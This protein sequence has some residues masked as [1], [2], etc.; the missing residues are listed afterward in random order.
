MI[1]IFKH[2]FTLP[3]MLVAALVADL[4]AAIAGAMVEFTIYIDALPDRPAGL[5]HIMLTVAAALCVNAML[6]F[7]LPAH[8]RDARLLARRAAFSAL[9]SA[10]LMS[11]LLWTLAEGARQGHVLASPALALLAATYVFRRGA[12]SGAP[13]S[14]ACRRILVFGTGAAALS[15]RQPEDAAGSSVEVLGYYPAA[16]SEVPAVPPERILPTAGRTLTQTALE[17]RVDEIVV[18]LNDRRGGALP[19]P[20]LLQCRVLGIRVHDLSTHFERSRGQIR[21]ESLRSGWLVF[22][23]GFEQGLLRRF[24]K[25]VFDIV[26]AGGMLVLAAPLMLITMALIA[27]ESG[28]SVF[29]QQ[30]RIGKDGRIFRILKFR[31]MRADAESD[32]KPRWAA[33]GDARVTRVGRLIR[34][35]RIDELPQLLNILAGEMSFCGPRP[36]RPF[37]VSQLREEL[38]Y[39]DL[40]HSV[41]PG[42]SGWAQVSHGYADSLAEAAEKLQYDLFYVKN[43]SLFLDMLILFKTI[44]V[45][46]DGRGAH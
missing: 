39:Y 38:Q 32:G 41:K 35:F 10:A 21:L 23:D 31:S 45:V 30:E 44:R 25:R 12:R 4:C 16:A 17:L 8:S 29:Y 37:F 14:E 24:S 36:E 20:E 28:G 42:L 13:R 26:L 2:W 11:F 40:R 22:G 34:R 15:V 7:Y 5:A 1:R 19:L 27:L 46:L 9:C 33:R 18:A 6:G 43:H 3:S